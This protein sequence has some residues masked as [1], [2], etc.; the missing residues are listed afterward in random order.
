M[1]GG[2]P[3]Q[4]W[5]HVDSERAHPDRLHPIC[6]GLWVALDRPPTR[7]R[8]CAEVCGCSIARSVACILTSGQVFRASG[9]AEAEPGTCTRGG[10]TTALRPI[11]GC[12]G[13]QVKAR[14]QGDSRAG[15]CAR[16]EP[17]WTPGHETHEQMTH[18]RAA[19]CPCA[20]S[21]RG[22]V[23]PAPPLAPR[24]SALRHGSPPLLARWRCRSSRTAPAPDFT[25]PRSA[26]DRLETRRHS[27]RTGRRP[28]LHR[29]P[30]ELT[31]AQTA[32]G[33]ARGRPDRETRCLCHAAN[34][35]AVAARPAP[36]RSRLATARAQERS[37]R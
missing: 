32:S 18:G 26:A 3:G 4:P 36:S 1:H 2:R 25:R 29:S 15:G 27:L 22:C 14:V 37:G 7:P 19:R 12:H 20:A 21:A 35:S 31:P 23:G 13:I 30:R 5:P 34:T 16:T 9:D 6:F 33:P 10:V 24:V 8:P 17:R 28:P 11:Q